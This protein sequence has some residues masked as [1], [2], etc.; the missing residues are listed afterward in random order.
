MLIFYRKIVLSILLSFLTSCYSVGPDYKKPELDLK[1]FKFKE[2]FNKDIKNISYDRWWRV[3]NDKKLNSLIETVLINN[4]DI[5]TQN[6][7][8][9]ELLAY[10]KKSKSDFYPTAYNYFEF[11]K[12]TAY[13]TTS[14]SFKLTLPISYE[15]DI[16]GKLRRTKESAFADLMQVKYN[17]KA[18]IHST[19][20]ETVNLYLSLEYIERKIG[21]KKRNIEAYENSLLIIE[22]K[23][24]KGLSTIL[25]L[26]Q[27]KRLLSKTKSELPP[28]IQDLELTQH[29][30]SM[31]SGKLPERSTHRLQ[32][33]DYFKLLEPVPVGLPS[34][35]LK[36]R[37]DI[38]SAEE[39][40]KSLNAKIGI[41]KANRFP[42]LTL[43]ATYGY[44]SDSMSTLFDSVSSISS[45]VSG[46]TTPI[47]NGGKLKSLQKI[48]EEQYKKGL[49][50]YYKT[51]LTAFK[52]V[53]D[54]LVTRENQL[55]KRKLVLKY[56]QDSEL[57]QKIAEKRYEKGLVDYQ[58]VLDTMQNTFI[59]EETLI[60]VD[61]AIY[62]N[63]V[64]LHKSIGGGWIVN[65]QKSGE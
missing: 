52:E 6:S 27:T 63:R 61:Y 5:K 49:Y 43:T 54:S 22:R 29:K 45:F 40:L 47:F 8:I 50:A 7:S 15:L 11:D 12:S 48:A 21:I 28:L 56:L 38:L 59:A 3:F 2:S 20:A 42:S 19:I 37:P 60:A 30:I 1:N 18:V 44:S 64:T 58:T 51:I 31:I 33:E 26:N 13:K 53:E 24:E 25:D 34:D 57:T 46:I 10:F 35:L 17:R 41:A 16:W 14:D 62:T 23:F 65:K 55:L 39:N 4:L 32:P 9:N 36:R